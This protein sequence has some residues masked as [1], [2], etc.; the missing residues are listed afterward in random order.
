MPVPSDLYTRSLRFL[1]GHPRTGQDVAIIWKALLTM[2]DMGAR[3]AWR[4][5]GGVIRS[6]QPPIDRILPI[7]RCLL[8]CLAQFGLGLVVAGITIA[9]R[10]WRIVAE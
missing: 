4:S 3:I 8:L 7:M 1:S 10:P 6:C 5:A 9:I 2:F